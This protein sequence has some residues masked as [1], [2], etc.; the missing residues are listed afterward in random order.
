MCQTIFMNKTKLRRTETTITT[1]TTKEARMV[2]TTT[3]EEKLGLNWAKLSSIWI[4]AVLKS[5][6][7]ASTV[8]MPTISHYISLSMSILSLKHIL[9]FT[10]PCHTFIPFQPYLTG[11]PQLPKYIHC[12][13]RPV[14]LRLSLT[15][16]TLLLMNIISSVPCE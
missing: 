4:S 9:S 7:T 13:I 12:T 1:K 15:F 10:N 6:F 2:I 11:L 16:A 8:R 3:I 5:R 14:V